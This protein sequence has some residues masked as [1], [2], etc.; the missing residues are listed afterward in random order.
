MQHISA[1]DLNTLMATK[2]VTLLDV[3]EPGEFEAAAIEGAINTPLSSFDL[4]NLP[5]EEGSDTIFICAVG[6][7]SQMALNAASAKFDA[8]S[9]Y[10]LDGGMR[11]WMMEGY[12]TQSDL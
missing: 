1:A 2:K 6:Q 8:E 9:L 12:P 5:I 3:R 4:E 7:R 11:A 10:N